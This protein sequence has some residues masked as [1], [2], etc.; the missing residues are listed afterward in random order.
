MQHRSLK[1]R[2]LAL[3]L[4]L[5]IIGVSSTLINIWSEI[6]TIDRG[7]GIVSETAAKTIADI[8]DR[9]LF[10]RYGDVQAF[11][12]S[13]A[14]ISGDGQ[15]IRDFMDVMIKIYAP[16]YDL[17]TVYDAK[18]ILVAVN[19]GSK[20]GQPLQMQRFIGQSAA[21]AEWFKA[22]TSG[23]VKPGTSFI[24]DLYFDAMSGQTFSSDGAAMAFSAPIH[25]K[26]GELIGV[27]RNVVSWKD[28]VQAVLA[29]SANTA[30]SES[31]QQVETILMR[32]DGTTL[33]DSSKETAVLKEKFLSSEAATA[34]TTPRNFVRD[35]RVAG[36]SGSAHIGVAPSKGYSSY[37][38]LNWRVGVMISKHD[39]AEG[40]VLVMAVISILLIFAT[41]V[42]V[43]VAI[44][45]TTAKLTRVNAGLVQATD[46]TRQAADAISTTSSELASA[47]TEQAAAVQETAASVEEMNAMVRKSA[48]NAEQSRRVA[49]SSQDAAGRSRAAVQSMIGAMDEI[50]A[51][52]SEVAHQ[53]EESNR[54]LVEITR[55]INEIGGKT[56]VINEIVFQTK[57][58]SFNASVEAARAGEHGK[59]F[60]VVAEEVGNLAQ[61]SGKAAREISDMLDGSIRR[62]EQIV[63]DTKTRVEQ[64]VRSGRAR[65]ETGVGLARQCDVALEEV[66]QNVTSVG[67]MVGE[68]SNATAE[69]SAGL[70]EITKAINQIDQVTHANS[71]A[72]RST[73]E[74]AERIAERVSTLAHNT[75]ELRQIVQGSAASPAARTLQQAHPSVASS[76]P[77]S[78]SHR[79][80]EFVRSAQVHELRRPSPS[81]A[82]VNDR[83]VS[84]A[85]GG[86]PRAAKAVGG[87]SVPM[88]DD[89]RFEDL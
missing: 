17:M 79:S 83:S 71:S 78:S 2:L 9:N 85:A 52:N 42:L 21:D 19:G 47:V 29:E 18:G 15:K 11:A 13:E 80:T 44:N 68:I 23:A 27:W 7:R 57:L 70:A 46:E 67:A 1:F 20:T 59:G 73:A 24:E 69:T 87:D 62:V 26:N 75:Q 45:R 56:K 40:D 54:Q 35:T 22:N 3:T 30:K 89:P 37:P 88:A 48:E 81:L 5:G 16:I 74:E 34:T 10:E 38:G 64:A 61:M 28:V 51:S 72:S 76:R 6:R 60:A 43:Y 41:M 50:N 36:L 77:T 25:G 55:V 4:V 12:S 58:L 65:V 31:V 32:Q 39:P 66:V 33:S 63:S 14:A 82:V 84:T 53:V 8:L 86:R 49:A